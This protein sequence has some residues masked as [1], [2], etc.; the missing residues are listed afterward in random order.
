MDHWHSHAHRR[1]F[2]RSRILSLEEEEG[3]TDGTGSRHHFKAWQVSSVFHR[4]LLT[5]PDTDRS[6]AEVV[7]KELVTNAKHVNVPSGDYFTR[8]DG[9][10]TTLSDDTYIAFV[11]FPKTRTEH[12]N[13]G[14][15][16]YGNTA[17]AF[18]D[19]HKDLRDAP[20]AV[21]KTQAEEERTIEQAAPAVNHR[22]APL[23]PPCVRVS[24]TAVY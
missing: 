24:Y 21:L 15:V 2:R 9:I 19:Y 5:R 4:V 16:F 20:Q 3:R 8:I 23:T 10:Y 12:H 6:K 1:V 14:I 22:S 7:L 18:Y 17:K 13:R 11:T